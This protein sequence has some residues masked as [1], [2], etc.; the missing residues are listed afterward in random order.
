NPQSAIC[1][2]L[3][4]VRRTSEPRGGISDCARAQPDATV[5]DRPRGISSTRA[6]YIA[7]EPREQSS[8]RP[9]DSQRTDDLARGPGCA[10]SV[11]M[12]DVLTRAEQ[13]ILL[14]RVIANLL[15]NADRRRFAGRVC[16]VTGAGGSVGSELAQ[17]LAACRPARLVL[18]DHCEHA[19]F[20]IEQRLSETDPDAVIE[21]VLCDVTR[22]VSVSRLLRRVRPDI[23]FHAA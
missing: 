13:E 6:K 17:Q 7:G 22:S 9:R 14:D 10:G 5:R 23:V 18:V 12:I 15:S 3:G 2:E 4:L 20:R 1:L 8:H 16:I 11:E 19:L 21:P